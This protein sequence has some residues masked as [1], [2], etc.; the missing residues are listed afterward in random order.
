M[1][2]M[3]ESPLLREVEGEREIGISSRWDAL[4]EELK[5]VSCIALPM[6]F[7]A[8]SQQ[9]VPTVAMGMLGHLGELYL[10]AAAI[11]TSLTNVT[12]FSLLVLTSTFSYLLLLHE[13]LTQYNIKFLN[14]QTQLLILVIIR[15]CR[16]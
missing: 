3:A 9:L 5:K 8:I 4:T 12:G 2:K 6:V 1:E 15:M 11:A 13:F 7:V 14:S 10:S 16:D